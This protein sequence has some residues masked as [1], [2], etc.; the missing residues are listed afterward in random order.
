MRP[1]DLTTEEKTLLVLIAQKGECGVFLSNEIV[2]SPAHDRLWELDLIV[3]V[4]AADGPPRGSTWRVTK[5]G[6]DRAKAIA[7]KVE[8][9]E[10]R[11]ARGVD[12]AE[13][14]EEH[15]VDGAA[16]RREITGLMPTLFCRC[17]HEASGATWAEAGAAYDAHL[18]GDKG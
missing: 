5:P 9:S 14:G 7:A 2:S 1:G 18:Q 13:D 3:G 12:E 17:A 15:A 8:Q 6:F 16:Y 11:V 4:G 10:R